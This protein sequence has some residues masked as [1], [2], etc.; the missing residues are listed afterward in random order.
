ML[1]SQ[2]EV[3][4]IISLL[5]MPG[6][7]SWGPSWVLRGGE[8]WQKPS[9]VGAETGVPGTTEKHTGGA[10]SPDPE[11][12]GVWGGDSQAQINR[13]QKECGGAS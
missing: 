6:M 13:G 9:T 7:L 2:P 3:L 11:A 12:Q 10:Q 5:D 1:G 4:A 8:V